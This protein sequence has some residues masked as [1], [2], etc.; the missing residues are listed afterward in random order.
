MVKKPH[1]NTLLDIIMM[2]SLNHYVQSFIKWLATLNALIV[3]RQCLLRLMIITYKKSI[4]KYGKKLA[5]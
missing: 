1:S 5:V 3:I 4:L 2:M